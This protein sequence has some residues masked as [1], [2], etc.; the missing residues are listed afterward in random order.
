MISTII[1]FAVIVSLLFLSVFL[2]LAWQG[3]REQLAEQERVNQAWR[4]R[5]RELAEISLERSKLIKSLT[6]NIKK[7]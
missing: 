7:E 2:W 3:A 4:D 6:N 5:Y 1:V